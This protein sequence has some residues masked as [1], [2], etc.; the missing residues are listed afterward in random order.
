V[1][2]AGV[3]SDAE[4]E[5]TDDGC[6]PGTWAAPPGLGPAHVAKTTTPVGRS[7]ALS[8]QGA[9]PSTGGTPQSAPAGAP[10][11]CLLASIPASVPSSDPAG[12]VPGT[13][14]AEGD[15]RTNQPT[16]LVPEGAQ[17]SIWTGVPAGTCWARV[18]MAALVS[19]TH[20]WLAYPPISHGW[21]VPWMATCP[22]P[23]SN[24]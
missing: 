12:S 14:V 18:V 21:F 15:R 19:R 10:P 23:P 1:A 24:W 3:P 4:R 9:D 7:A 2:D 22:G 13:S 5:A 17:G 11:R 16:N 20:P 6:G 8:S